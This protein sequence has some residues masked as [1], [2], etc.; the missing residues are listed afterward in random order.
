MIANN[1]GGYVVLSTSIRLIRPHFELTAKFLIFFFF[2]G[3]NT[4]AL[5][6]FG[7]ESAVLF[8]VADVVDRGIE[9]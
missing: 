5:Y 6:S 1:F 7:S 9:T 3:L 2:F 8:G 4:I